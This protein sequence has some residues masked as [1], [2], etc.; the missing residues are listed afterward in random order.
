MANKETVLFL[1]TGNSC[2]SQMGEGLL[3]DMAGDRYDVISAGMDPADQTHPMAV[4]VMQEIGIDISAQ[5]PTPLR[6]YLGKTHVHW[7]VIVCD[8]ANNTCPTVWPGLADGH[9][10]FWPFDDPAHAT[11]TDEEKLAV[12]RRVRDEISTKLREWTGR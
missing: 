6:T 7:L 10:L 4:Q 11:G 8:N 12:F 5:E 2:R 9:K 1:C 3:R